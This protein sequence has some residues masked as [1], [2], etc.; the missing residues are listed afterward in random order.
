VLKFLLLRS[1]Q[2]T[3]WYKPAQGNNSTSTDKQ[4]HQ[5]NMPSLLAPVM[6][7]PLPH[8]Q[9]PVLHAQ[10]PAQ[11]SQQQQEQQ[12]QQQ[13]QQRSACQRGLK[14]PEPGHDV[15]GTEQPP[16]AT[17]G[18]GSGTGTICPINGCLDEQGKGVNKDVGR[19]SCPPVA[20][21]TWSSQLLVL[22]LGHRQPTKRQR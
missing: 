10:S 5:Q 1:Y 16:V 9:Q 20:W 15:A 7:T 17:R 8:Y 12:Q 14:E 3:V 18:D 6:V 2:A 11:R 4:Q 19:C 21:S 13:Q 22:M